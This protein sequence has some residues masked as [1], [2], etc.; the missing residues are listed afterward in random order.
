VKWLDYHN[1]L[2]I[3][4]TAWTLVVGATGVINTISPPIYAA[5][6]QG[7]VARIRAPGA[8]PGPVSPRQL[9]S[10]QAAMDMALAA[11]PGTRPQFVAFPGA[12][13]ASARHYAVYLQGV[14]PATKRLLT[15]VLIDAQ[16]GALAP[17]QPMPWILQTL[18]R[19]Q[20]LHFGDYGGTPLKVLWAILDLFT[21]VVLGSGLYLWLGRPAR[22][23]TGG[24]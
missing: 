23:P 7:E 24:A 4:V 11:A 12:E 13:Y 18:L 20:P 17:I 10:L 2:G 8:D 22:P 5:W 6:Q 15:P 19:L 9:S 16:T 1:L 21:I 3:V 14:T